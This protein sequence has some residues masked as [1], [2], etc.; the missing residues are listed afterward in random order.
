MIDAVVGVGYFVVFDVR[1]GGRRNRKER[2][3]IDCKNGE[4]LVGIGDVGV[5][6]ALREIHDH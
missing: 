3:W 2:I 1:E 6:N 5:V 4:G